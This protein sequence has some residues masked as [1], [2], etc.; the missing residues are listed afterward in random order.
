MKIEKRN[1]KMLN[2]IAMVV[3]AAV[4]LTVFGGF[5]MQQQSMP[6]RDG[7]IG[8][9][10]NT[11]PMQPASAQSGPTGTL[12]ISAGILLLLAGFGVIV[13]LLWAGRKLDHNPS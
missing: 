1:L 5:I 3:L 11:N 10:R 7:D 6:S 9:G 13:V 12:V 4:L 2:I 8:L